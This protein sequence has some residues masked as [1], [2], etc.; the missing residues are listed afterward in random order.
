[1]LTGCLISGCVIGITHKREVV[2]RTRVIGIELAPEGDRVAVGVQV[3]HVHEPNALGEFPDGGQWIY[4]KGT[5]EVLLFDLRGRG[6]PRRF[7]TLPRRSED[8]YQLLY[9]DSTGIVVLG[10]SGRAFRVMRIDPA[11]GRSATLPPA[12]TPI[13]HARY[14]KLHPG[15]S[16]WDDLRRRRVYESYGQFF[17]WNPETRHAEHLFDLPAV[18]DGH[19]EPRTLQARDWRR[20]RLR[21]G[22]LDVWSASVRQERDSARVMLETYAARPGDRARNYRLTTNVSVLDTIA[23]R[24][25]VYQGE[26]LAL[27]SATRLLLPAT[28]RVDAVV[29]YD[30]LRRRLRPYSRY[31]SMWPPDSVEVTLS[32][33]L[34]PLALPSDSNHL[35]P[36]QY[37]AGGADVVVT[38]PARGLLVRRP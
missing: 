2:S 15:R 13:A 28:T 14:A 22:L 34:H 25:N 19:R 7:A 32:V 21:D 36:A 4:E 33:R 1:V 16:V 10:G 31:L 8:H 12:A 3:D 9:W 38:V 17:L 26:T 30:D 18:W 20:E 6:S 27:D 29:A 11:S 37:H 24:R 35:N 5:F 23:I